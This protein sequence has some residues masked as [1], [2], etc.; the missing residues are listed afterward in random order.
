MRNKELPSNE[1]FPSHSRVHFLLTL[2][3]SLTF[4][5][6]KS[7]NKA[8]E[9]R[10][11]Q[12]PSSIGVV[13]NG[14]LS[15]FIT[16][17]DGMHAISDSREIHTA[18]VELLRAINEVRK[19]RDVRKLHRDHGARGQRVSFSFHKHVNFHVPIRLIEVLF[20]IVVSLVFKSNGTREAC[21][22]QRCKC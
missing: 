19:R 1:V 15:R 11:K 21:W 2:R 20:L 12:N 4:D 9:F 14:S 13:E 16:F 8:D 3:A 22:R 6:Q 17:G 7:F 5:P 10:M 18:G